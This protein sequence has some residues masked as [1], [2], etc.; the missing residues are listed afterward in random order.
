MTLLWNLKKQRLVACFH[1]F[2][3]AN[4]F[5]NMSRGRL[6]A[7]VDQCANDNDKWALQARHHE[8]TTIITSTIQPAEAACIKP[9]TGDMQ[10]DFAAAQT[11]HWRMTRARRTS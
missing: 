3:I 7:V 4:A 5:P 8:A 1:F 9:T 11:L 2:D 10:G 6:D